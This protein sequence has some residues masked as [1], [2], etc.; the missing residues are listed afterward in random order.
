MKYIITTTPIFN[1][2]FDD[3]KYKLIYMP[4]SIKN[5]I[6]VINKYGINDYLTNLYIHSKVGKWYKL[7]DIFIQSQNELCNIT[8]ATHFILVNCCVIINRHVI[9]YCRKNKIY[10]LN[11]HPGRI[12]CPGRHP[13]FNSQK[14]SA[15]G[16]YCHE[17]T[18]KIDDTQNVLYNYYLYTQNQQVGLDF[19]KTK[20]EYILKKT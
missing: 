20:T 9:S 16:I 2:N 13:L 15:Y 12:D 14:T 18:N 7:F 4:M 17:V 8:D 1:Y 11:I 6:N 10:I 5:E 19:I 3:T